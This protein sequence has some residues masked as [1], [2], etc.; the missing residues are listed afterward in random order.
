[1]YKTHRNFSGANQEKKKTKQKK[2][3]T[4]KQQKKKT[5]NKVLIS[6]VMKL[7]NEYYL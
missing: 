5:K 2:K 1:M 6:N 3:K 4:K 7:Y